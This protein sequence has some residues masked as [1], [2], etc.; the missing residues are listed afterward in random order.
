MKAETLYSPKKL[1]A[2]IN[3]IEK[4][5]DRVRLER[6]GDRTLDIDIVFTVTRS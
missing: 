4:D 1:L 5:G 3:A 2:T 6:W